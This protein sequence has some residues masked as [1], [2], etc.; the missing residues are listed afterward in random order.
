MRYLA[1][2][3]GLAILVGCQTTP[4]EEYIWVRTD[5][6]RAAD[7]PTFAA[8]HELDRTVCYGDVQKSAAGAPVIYYQGLSGAIS[9]SMIADQRQRGYLDIMKGCMAG[10]GYVLVPISQAA[11][12]SAKYKANPIPRPAG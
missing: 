10:K 7:N 2:L 12:T 11:A 8:Q 3:T 5:G 6:Q 4:A 9:A 1:A